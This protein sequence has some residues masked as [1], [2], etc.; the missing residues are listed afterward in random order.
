[1]KSNPRILQSRFSTILLNRLSSHERTEAKS[2]FI[3]WCNEYVTPYL[4]QT[5][6]EIPIGPGFYEAF[7]DFIFPQEELD[8]PASPDTRNDRTSSAHG[9]RKAPK[10]FLDKVREQKADGKKKVLRD[11]LLKKLR[12][13]LWQPDSKTSQQRKTVQIDSIGDTRAEGQLSSGLDVS[14]ITEGVKSTTSGSAF[15]VPTD[16]STPS[17]ELQDKER[18]ELTKKHF[19]AIM[20]RTVLLQLKGEKATHPRTWNGQTNWT[21]QEIEGYRQLLEN[22]SR[23]SAAIQLGKSHAGFEQWIKRRKNLIR[24]SLN[25]YIGQSLRLEPDIEVTETMKSFCR[26]ALPESLASSEFSFLGLRLVD[27]HECDQGLML[28]KA[29]LLRI[30]YHCDTT[31]DRVVDKWLPLKGIDWIN[32]NPGLPISQ[33]RLVPY[34]FSPQSQFAVETLRLLGQKNVGLQP[35]LRHEL[36]GVVREL[37]QPLTKPPED[38]RHHLRSILSGEEITSK[39]LP[40][41]LPHE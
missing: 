33:P 26:L 22:D 15:V 19:Y 14:E 38:F 39:L 35:I 21:H 40:S 16:S 2:D 13:Y 4:G 27:T 8:L 30:L 25:D 5:E 24:Q 11:K 20:R 28:M 6:P 32:S 34:T 37:I 1:M 41:P 3:E 29:E 12:S 7:Y 23:K 17:T 18:E 9:R 10:R 31:L 36:I